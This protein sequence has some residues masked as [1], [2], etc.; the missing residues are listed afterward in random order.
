MDI[1]GLP[2]RMMNQFSQMNAAAT[3]APAQPVSPVKEP[4]TLDSLSSMSERINHIAS[5]FDVKALPVSDIASLQTSLKDSGLIQPTQV[6]AQGLLT[7]LAYRH[8]EAGPMDLEK[9]LEEHVGSLKDKSA[10]LADH[11]EGKYMLNTVRNLMSA[12]EQQGHAA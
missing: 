8:Y 11:K 10:V 6:R 12:R 5:Q 9:A 1:M 3:V 7:Q 2:K 4:V